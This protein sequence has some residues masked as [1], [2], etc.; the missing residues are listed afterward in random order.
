MDTPDSVCRARPL[1]GT[2][3]EIRCA[4][5]TRLAA[6]RAIDAAFAAIAK[7][8][9]QMSFHIPTATS[10]VSIVRPA[11]RASKSIRGPIKF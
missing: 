1:L 11:N 7:V 5:A 2:F 8:H 9:R 10:A 3:V 4:G 6:E